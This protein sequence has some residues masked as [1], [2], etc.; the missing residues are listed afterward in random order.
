MK[1]AMGIRKPACSLLIFIL[2]AIGGVQLSLG[3]DR[4]LTLAVGL[5]LPPYNIQETD[6]GLE[7][8]IVRESLS[9]KGYTVKTKFVPFARVK[10]E[11][12]GEKVDGALTITPASGI[13]AFYSDEHIVCE[14]VAVSLESS[15]FDIQNID[16]LS[17]KR[18]VAFQDA[19]RYLGDTFKQM[20]EANP[21]YREIADQ[22]LQI[23]LLYSG[24][25]DAI[26]LDKNIFNYHRKHNDRV[27][28]TQPVNIWHIFEPSP[29]RVAFID[30]E[31]RNDFNEGLR[32]LRESGRYQKIMEKYVSH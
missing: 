24:R 6:A 31:V 13:V 26:I 2:A 30:K 14:N 3:G 10:R 5:S 22:M 1:P 19:T 18:V 11:L 32:K 9:M 28:T 29:F 15:D 20:A 21:A 17:G 7:L 23:N 4:E 16:D 25:T 8:D 12:V 27:D